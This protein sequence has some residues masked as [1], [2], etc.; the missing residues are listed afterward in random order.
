MFR[1]FKVGSSSLKN[2]KT[3]YFVTDAYDETE[4]DIRPKAVEFPISVLFDEKMQEKRA[5]DYA[6]YLNKLVEAT[7]QAYEQNQL[8]NILKS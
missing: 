7:T 2:K 6:N 8:I 5:D 4:L 1:T 3:S